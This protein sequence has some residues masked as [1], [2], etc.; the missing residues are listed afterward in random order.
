[1]QPGADI[2]KVCPE[3][4]R[5][6]TVRFVLSSEHW[7]CGECFR[8]RI[9]PEDPRAPKYWMYETGGE[10]AQAIER[11]LKF[12]PLHPSDILLMRAYCRQWID[13]PVWERKPTM[14]NAA[15]QELAELRRTVRD[16]ETRQQLSIWLY[17]AEGF[18]ADPL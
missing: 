15:R 2:V 1:M 11:F 3:C 10:L 18:G 14:T 5:E 12:E 4:G 9:A 6:T 13:S 7:L 17:A 8:S 16:I